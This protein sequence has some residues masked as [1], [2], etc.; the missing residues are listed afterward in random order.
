MNPNNLNP[1]QPNI[2]DD[3]LARAV[4]WFLSFSAASLG[5]IVWMV[6]KLLQ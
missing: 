4:I 2:H 1:S 6:V 3:I 5:V